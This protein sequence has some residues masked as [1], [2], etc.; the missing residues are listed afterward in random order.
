MT[1]F[2]K[3]IAGEMIEKFKKENNFSKKLAMKVTDI[4]FN[5]ECGWSKKLEEVIEKET[6]KLLDEIVGTEMKYLRADGGFGKPL[7]T[8]E[9]IDGWNKKR[10][11][12]IQII[13][14]FK[15]K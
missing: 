9:F 14:K 13:N 1:K 4:I 6:Q 12:I 5:R 11:E 2:N 10:H 15:G 7:Y 8:G 3:R